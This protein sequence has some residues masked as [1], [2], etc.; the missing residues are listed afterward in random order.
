MK[1]YAVN[2]NGNKYCGPSA[3]SAIAGIGTKEAAAVIRLASNKSHIKGT[4]SG[5]VLRAL[6]KLGFSMVKK[7]FERANMQNWA[8]VTARGKDV[9]LIAAGNHWVLVQGRYAICGKTKNLVAVTEHPSARSFIKDAY[10]I[11]KIK[12]VDAQTVIPVQ[13]KVEA[14][15]GSAR[16][17]AM[18]LAAKYGI[19]AYRDKELDSKPLWVGPPEGMFE[20]EDEEKDPF[21]GDHYVYEWVEAL[22]RVEEYVKVVEAA[23]ANQAV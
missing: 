21:Y 20:G 11:C 9:Y 7:S 8:R 2:Q 22:E 16:R 14:T 6:H 5:E 4:S 15:E 10:L 18:A 3:I 19:Q 1:L 23:K 17:K 12:N 13:P